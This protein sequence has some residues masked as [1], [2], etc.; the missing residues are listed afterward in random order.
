MNTYQQHLDRRITALQWAVPTLLM[1]SVFA[2]Q[3][4]VSLWVHNTFNDPVHFATEI[5]FFGTTGPLLAYWT[6][7]QIRRWL[8][9]KNQAEEEARAHKNRLAAITNASADAILGINIQGE[10]DSWN[11][12]AARLFA[13]EEHQMLGQKLAMLFGMGEAALRESAWL[14]EQTANTGVVHGHEAVCF[15]RDGSQFQAEITATRISGGEQGISLIVRDITVRKQRENEIRILNERLNQQVEERT[16]QL[17]EKIEQLAEANQSLQHLDKVRTDFVSLVSHQ[18]RAPLTNLQGALERMQTDCNILH[19]TCK[20]MFGIIEQQTERLD[21]LVRDVLNTNRI[22]AGELV[23]QVEP[24]SIRPILQETIKQ[25]SARLEGHPIE[26]ESAPDIPLA[27]GDHDRIVEV[28]INL[29]DNAD[30]YSPKGEPIHISLKADIGEVTVSIRD[31]GAGLPPEQFDRVFEKFYRL[32]SGDS[33]SAYGYGLGL[34]ICQ[35]LIEAQNGR[36]W[37]EN[38]PSGGAVFSFALPIWQDPA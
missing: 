24:V 5:L 15:R 21:R 36:I 32:S 31:G 38:H 26:F 1:A 37:A 14:L 12:G 30:K 28:V 35:R 3:L 27:L 25:V 16:H 33:Q 2:Y 8:A 29:L 6:L 11:M 18:L 10:V 13:R 23:V 20:R 34:Y 19:P 22:E 7:G 9:E 4:G 17:A